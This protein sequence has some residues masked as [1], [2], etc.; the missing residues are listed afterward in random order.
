MTRATGHAG[1]RDNRFECAET[2][3]GRVAPLWRTTSA[4]QFVEAVRS[5]L[6]PFD[7]CPVKGGFRGQ[8]DTRTADLNVA[9]DI[10]CTPLKVYRNRYGSGSTTSDDV[11]K[12]IWQVSG[13]GEMEQG[14]QFLRLEP[15][16]LALYRLARPYQLQTSGSYRALTLSFDLSEMPQWRPL[17]NRYGGQA[18][19]VDSASLAAL[20]AMRSLFSVPGDDSIASVMRGAIEL[21]FRSLLRFARDD[22]HTVPMPSLCLEQARKAATARLADPDFSPDDLARALQISRRSLY[23]EFQRH[24]MPPPATFIRDLRLARCHAALLDPELRDRSVTELAFENGFSD[25]AHFS[26]AF[27]DCYGTAPSFLRKRRTTD[28]A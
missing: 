24:G 6:G 15:G 13:V 20:A 7:I 27:R 23:A 3:G 14:G 9:G 16:N 22:G 4:D 25:S 19:P 12:V 28:G 2:A 18:L 10:S 21:V 8:L 1:V 26:R 17:A 11:F 5:R